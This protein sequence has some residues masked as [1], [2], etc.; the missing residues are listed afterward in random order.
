[1]KRT[2]KIIVRIIL[3]LCV[4]LVAFGA[5]SHYLY[6]GSQAA[7][8]PCRNFE[9][10]A[11]AV[12]V[13]GFDLY[14][15]EMGTDTTQTPVVLIHGGPG[16]SSQTFKDGFDFLAATRRVIFYDQRGSGNSQIKPGAKFY[17]IGRLVEELES[18]R[19]EV[20]GADQMTL[21]AHSAGGTLALRYALAYPNRVEKLV[22][23]CA[24][25]ANGGM[26]VGGVGV[27]MVVAAMYTLSGA[28][29]PADPLQADAEFNDLIFE[30]NIARLYDSSRTDLLQ[31][32]GYA[33]FAVNRDITRSS[34]GGNFD[35]RLAHLTF[36]VL[37]I[38]GKADDSPYTGAAVAQR[39]AAALPNTMLVAMEHSG[40][41]PYLEEPATF[42]AAI[43]DFLEP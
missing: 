28:L 7:E 4:V 20:I 41:W 31:G 25:P 1:M 2:L 33:S 32:T 18:L 30:T 6:Y 9:D 12:N 19:R 22:L 23:V 26:A 8:L 34:L 43:N 24:L 16:Q 21:I 11:R 35:A 5:V 42:Q 40:H 38:Y 36:P 39:L 3:A 13:G 29:P 10:D 37:V 17:T 14:Y 27:E 15:R